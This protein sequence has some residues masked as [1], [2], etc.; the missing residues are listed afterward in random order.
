[1]LRTVVF[2]VFFF[3]T[4]S[5]YLRDKGGSLHEFLRCGGLFIF[6]VRYVRC[7]VC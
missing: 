2:C 4:S 1:M 6:H 5:F 3:F 7:A